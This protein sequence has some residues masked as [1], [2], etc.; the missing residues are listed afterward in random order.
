MER[1]VYL[2]WGLL[3]FNTLTFFGGISFIPI[4]SSVGKALTQVTLPA[5]LLIALTINRRLFIRP[6]VL[7]CLISLLVVGTILTSLDPQH[8]GTVYRSVRLAMFVATLWLLTPWWG[9]RDLLLVRCHLAVQFVI[10]GSV[11]VGLCLAPSRALSFG[12]LVGALWP[13]PAPQVAH[14]AAVSTG[15]IAVLWFCGRVHGRMPLLAVTGT[16]LILVLTHTRTALVGMVAGIL[17]AGLSLI[18]TSHRVRWLF[19]SACVM[20]AVVVMTLSSVLLNWLARGEGSDEL[21]SLTGRTTVWSGILTTPRNWF[22]ETFGF[23]LS[24]ASYNGLSIDSN[25][26]ASYQEQG[27]YGVILCGTIL[28]FLIVTAY[29]QPRGVQRALALFLITYCLVASFTEVGFTDATPYLLEI[30]LAA[31]LL[32]P[33]QSQSGV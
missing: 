20:A 25:W 7:L 8:F 13:I 18:V 23:G 32:V 11:I 15:L 17:V 16:I 12:R 31:S 26:L 3:Y 5:A 22:Q 27:L 9:R 21:T 4:P 1:R 19:G 6:N 2:T 28:V 24:N 33:Q 30:T 29:F 10:L 14:Y